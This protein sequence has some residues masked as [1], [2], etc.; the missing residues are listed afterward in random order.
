[1]VNNP[2]YLPAI[3][4]CGIT[5]VSDALVAAKAGARYLGY[6]LNYSASPRRLTAAD[7]LNI[8]TAVRASYPKVQHVGVTV[9]LQA[10]TIND[11]VRRLR[12]DVVQ[13]HGVESIETVQAVRA[14]QIWKS[15]IIRSATDVDHILAYLPHVQAVHLDAGRGSGRTIAHSLLKPAME[16]ISAAAMTDSA[17][18][19]SGAAAVVL[20]GGIAP[21]NIHEF[22]PYR[23]VALDVN[24]GVESQPG[25]KD[26]ALIN[27]LFQNTYAYA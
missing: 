5:N 8:I 19:S 16:K 12:L 22:L 10:A 24:S 17:G 7:A 3:K 15:T 25:K 13:L 11:L 20:A 18:Q 23:A 14:P 21:D 4:V 1:M 26:P 6:V 27:R 2:H 9:D